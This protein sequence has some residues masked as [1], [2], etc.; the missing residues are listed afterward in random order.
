MNKVSNSYMR[1]I[2][3]SDET[4]CMNLNTIK[5]IL[6]SIK[7]FLQ[8]F[9]YEIQTWRE[10]LAAMSKRS[11]NLA[12]NSL[13][14]LVVCLVRILAFFSLAS[15]NLSFVNSELF[16]YW[17]FFFQFQMLLGSNSGL[18]SG[19]SEIEFL[20]DGGMDGPTDRQTDGHSDG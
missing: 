18:K 5:Q 3:V 19:F 10:S 7:R 17:H 15:T 12:M 6:L 16:L 1:S 8:Y 13:S 14:F 11:F 4:I 9:S 20:C 2:K